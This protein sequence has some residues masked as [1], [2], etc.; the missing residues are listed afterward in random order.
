[1]TMIDKRAREERRRAQCEG[2]EAL[3][4][5]GALDA[6]YA[7]IDA[8]EVRLEGKD[9]LIQQLIKA[10][11]ERGLQAELS[12][13]LGYDKGDPEAGRYPNSRNGYSA[14][15]V[16]TSVGDVELAIP[17]DR[18]G[19]FTPTLVPKGSRLLQRPDRSASAPIRRPWTRSGVTRNRSPPLSF[20][21]HTHTR[22]GVTRRCLVLPAFSMIQAFVKGTHRLQGRWQRARIAAKSCFQTSL[23]EVRFSA[24]G[25]VRIDADVPL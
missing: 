13:H 12:G 25:P 23:E 11:L 1:M 10:G 8:G 21:C 17:R 20:V 18:D 14:K 24:S 16:A 3:E 15:T 19:T 7:K 6:L 4:A 2:V 5:S 22:P 9:G